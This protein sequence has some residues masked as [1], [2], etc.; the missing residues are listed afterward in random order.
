MKLKGNFVIKKIADETV[1]IHVNGNV[2]DLRGAISLKGSAETIFSALLKGAKKEEIVN[3]LAET[4]HISNST[5]ETD[6]ENFLKMLYNNNLLE[7]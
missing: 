6:T 2:A 4:Y 5:A 7:G 1:A 3:L